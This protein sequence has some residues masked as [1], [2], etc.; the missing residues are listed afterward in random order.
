MKRHSAGFTLIE[1]MVALA[2][3]AIA[4]MAGLQASSALT[5]N[6]ARQAQVLGAQLCAE[7][8]LTLWRLQRQLPPI[9][10]SRIACEQA[11]E[12]FELHLQ[13]LPTPNPVFRRIDAH[14][15]HGEQPVLRISTIQGRQ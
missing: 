12:I 4:L 2:I 14:V 8:Q 13:V 11:G 7:N 1:V 15:W 3:V 10:D 5:R 9:G 6:A